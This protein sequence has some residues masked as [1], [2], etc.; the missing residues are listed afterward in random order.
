VFAEDAAALVGNL[1]A[2]AGIAL[3]QATGSWVPDAIAAISI[4]VLLG[5]VALQLAAGRGLDSSITTK[6]SI[7]R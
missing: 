7:G 1:I 5:L 4:C 6:E 2:A 3:H